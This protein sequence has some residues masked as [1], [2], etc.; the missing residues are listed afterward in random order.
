M[1]KQIAVFIL[2]LAIPGVFGMQNTYLD[3]Y[4]VDRGIRTFETSS[5]SDFQVLINTKRSINLFSKDSVEYSEDVAEAAFS[6]DKITKNEN[7]LWLTGVKFASSTPRTYVLA[8][9]GTVLSE[10][11]RFLSHDFGAF[12]DQESYYMSTSISTEVESFTGEDIW[13]RNW[14]GIKPLRDKRLD[15]GSENLLLLDGRGN[16][17]IQLVRGGE[18]LWEIDK[19]SSINGNI[20]DSGVLLWSGNTLSVRFLENGSAVWEKEVGA[21]RYRPV[22]VEE[23]VFYAARSKLVSRNLKNGE[24]TDERELGVEVDRLKKFP[25]EEWLAARHGE[26]ISVFSLEG[27]KIHTFRAPGIDEGFQFTEHDGDSMKEIAYG[28]GDTVHVVD[29]EEERTDFNHSLQDTVF[30]GS[31]EE[32]LEAVSL[33]QTAFVAKDF[34]NVRREVE[35]TGLEPLGVGDVDGVRSTEE[36]GRVFNISGEKYYP[37]SREKAVYV[38]VFAAEDNASLTFEKTEAD[39]DFSNYSIEELQEKFVEEF[40]PH[41]VAVA[42]LDS[43]KGALAAYMAVSQ[44]VLPVDFDQEFSYP[45]ESEGVDAGRW[46]ENNGVIKLEEEV[47]KAFELIGENPDTVFDGKYV[48]IIGGPRRMHEDPVEKGIID[49]PKDGSRFHSDLGYGDLDDDGRLEAGV[50]RYPEKVG[51]ASAVYHRSLQREKGREAVLAGEYLHSRW[52]V[53]L[54]T[55]GGGMWDVKNLGYVLEQQGFEVTRMV[56]YRSRPIA[57]ITD[58]LGFPTKLDIFTSEMKSTQDQLGKYI[59]ASGAAVAK[60]AAFAIRGLTYAERV[61]QLYL[62]FDWMNWEPAGQELDLP[63]SASLEEVRKLAYS[64]LP[65]RH[66]KLERSSLGSE[67]G[68]ADII[69]LQLV[70][71]SSGYAMPGN[72]SGFHESRYTSKK[73]QASSVPGLERPVT[74]DN[75]N[76]AGRRNAKMK[77]TYIEKGASSFLGFS[78]VNYEAYSSYV[79]RRFFRHGKTLGESLKDSV[80]ELRSAR[81]VLNPASAYK[82]GVRDKMEKSLSLYGNPEMVK[83]PVEEPGVNTSHTCEEGLCELEVR[84][85]PEPEIVERNGEKRVVFN[86][87]DYLLQPYSPI[88]PLYSYRREVPRGAEVVDSKVDHSYR[89]IEGLEPERKVLLDHSETFSNRS[90]DYSEFPRTLYR[91]NSSQ[92]EY[93]QA[94]AQYRENSSRVLE[95]AT[96]KVIYRNPV[97]LELE[98]EGNSLYAEIYSDQERDVELGYMIDGKEMTRSLKLDKGSQRVGLSELSK[99]VHTTEAFVYSETVLSRDMKEFKIGESVKVI[100]FAPDMHRGETRKVRVVARNSN[101]FPVSRQLKLSIDKN[102]IMGILEDG[103]RQVSLGPGETRELSWRITAIKTG[104]ANVS[105]GE[106][107]ETVEVERGRDTSRLFSPRQLARKISGPTSSF[108][109]RISQGEMRLTWRTPRGRAELFQNTTHERQVLET[110]EFR[111]SLTKTGSREVRK[112]STG[113]GSYTEVIKGGNRQETRKGRN[114]LAEKR[115]QMLE[116]EARKLRKYVQETDVRMLKTKRKIE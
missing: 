84:F 56:E 47:G 64:F 19:P 24:K 101:S 82:A 21:E 39:R 54:A 85:E 36:V 97:T 66:E 55:F 6:M 57:L 38:S 16:R 14:Q 58:L 20:L 40:E 53:I 2:I 60:N 111:A 106:G 73:F 62:E 100:V 43:D 77:Q 22:V 71:N 26:K 83:D 91:L 108:S 90:L 114:V 87:S 34:E 1:R 72:R 32:M 80:N 95:E 52:P 99:G 8:E 113:E 37:G 63:E 46:N 104:S 33:N 51:E 28:A 109:S 81:L 31:G 25:G 78:S 65:D 94:A 15:S 7:L 76:N 17:P 61:L 70:G 50:G 79:S 92:L 23:K 4:T 103:E 41:H 42:D 115:S 49:D 93:V 96:A 89:E 105:V 86:T 110:R 107:S 9:N 10:I 18:L 12:V 27:E 44:G 35:A 5:N 68:T 88:T 75:S 11:P 112:I 3:N 69:Y 67:M 102:L 30:V 29:L 48:S 98:R 116:E 59:G 45:G 13:S 74:W